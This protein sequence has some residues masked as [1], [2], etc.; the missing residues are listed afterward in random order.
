LQGK[1]SLKHHQA[2]KTRLGGGLEVIDVVDHPSE[3]IPAHRFVGAA[4]RAL[5]MQLK[6][7]PNLRLEMETPYDPDMYMGIRVS[8]FELI[9]GR[10]D[11]N[12]RRVFGLEHAPTIHWYVTEEGDVLIEGEA[13]GGEPRS[14]RHDDVP[15]I[16]L[17]DPVHFFKFAE[18]FGLAQGERLLR[19]NHRGGRPFLNEPVVGVIDELRDKARLVT[20]HQSRATV[21]VDVSTLQARIR[22]ARTRELADARALANDL[23]LNGQQMAEPQ[24]RATYVCIHR[25]TVRAYGPRL[26][27]SYIETTSESG[28]EEVHVA[29]RPPPGFGSPEDTLKRYGELFGKELAG[30]YIR[31]SIGD[32]TQGIA[33]LLG[34]HP[35]DIILVDAN[36]HPADAW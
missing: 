25:P 6:R 35:D 17:D 28:E 13:Y 2:R 4:E 20:R 31:G 36:S 10:C 27:F 34:Y 30:E 19:L 18:A 23:L 5:G 32:A 22:V 21:V 26:A 33:D 29:D 16:R 24:A 8:A 1:T 15:V 3:A 12:E 11:A 7:M 14:V 9:S